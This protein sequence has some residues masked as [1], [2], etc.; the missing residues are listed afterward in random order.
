MYYFFIYI[1]KVILKQNIMK[2]FN[3]NLIITFLL[4]FIAYNFFEDGHNGT[5][6]FMLVPTSFSVLY[7]YVKQILEDEQ[8]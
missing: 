5:A 1:Y 8:N 4:L 7:G 6:M 2:D 3:Y